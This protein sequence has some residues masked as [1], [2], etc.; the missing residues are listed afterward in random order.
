MNTKHLVGL[1]LNVLMSITVFAATDDWAQH[2]RYATANQSL[3]DSVQVVFIGNSI[4]DHWDDIHPEFF[5][6]NHY[7][8]RGIS[9]QVSSQM[10]VRFQSDVIRL[11]PR[12]VVILAGTNDIA[13]NNGYIAIEHIAENVQSMCELAQFHHIQPIICS[14]LPVYQYPWRKEVIAPADTIRRLNTILRAYAEANHIPYVDYYAAL[15]DE[16]GGLPEIYSNDGVHPISA[17]Y[18]IMERLITAEISKH[19]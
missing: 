11:H 9:G 17:G 13:L 3:E 2:N 7:A 5:S 10:L 14:V 12:V 1:C 18:D 4:T 8:N 19:L 6:A 15:V 16:R